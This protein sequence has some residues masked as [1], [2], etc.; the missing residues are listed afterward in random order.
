MFIEKII[1]FS[2]FANCAIAKLAQ[3]TYIAIIIIII[4]DIADKI[5][6]NKKLKLIK[7]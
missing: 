2:D 7:K 5:Q 6:N 1:N 3:R 4:R